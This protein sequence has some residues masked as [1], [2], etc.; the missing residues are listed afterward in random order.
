MKYRKEIRLS[1]AEQ[2]KL[3]KGAA[4]MVLSSVYINHSLLLYTPLIMGSAESSSPGYILIG[5]QTT[6]V[7]MYDLVDIHAYMIYF[8][9]QFP[10]FLP[11]FRMVNLGIR[12]FWERLS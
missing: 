3:T 5:I 2:D 9:A 7:V 8:I 4:E 11:D 6:V 12:R 10:Q 1:A